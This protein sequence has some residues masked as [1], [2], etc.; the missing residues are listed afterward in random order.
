MRKGS[1]HFPNGCRSVFADAPWP[2][3]AQ[4]RPRLTRRATAGDVVPF[5]PSSKPRIKEKRTGVR[6]D[7]THTTARCHAS[8][9]ISGRN[10]TGDVA[11]PPGR[12][13]EVMSWVS[14]RETT[15]MPLESRCTP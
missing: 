6:G 14:A 2:R 13:T 9:G 5:E 10:P 12:Y 8:F 7:F 11:P 15:P 3:K 1:G 4:H